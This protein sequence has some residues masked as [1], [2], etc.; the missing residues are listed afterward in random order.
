MNSRKRKN[1]PISIPQDLLANKRAKLL[2]SLWASPAEDNSGSVTKHP[3]CPG[4]SCSERTAAGEKPERYPADW[5]NRQAAGEKSDF[6]P[7]CVE[8]TFTVADCRK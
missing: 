1:S 7:V 4:P 2:S 8:F 5:Q 6:S 3:S